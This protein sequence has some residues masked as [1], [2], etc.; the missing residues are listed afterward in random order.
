VQRHCPVGR[1]S[2][3]A[4]L[5][6]LG[7][8]K[9]AKCRLTGHPIKDLLVGSGAL[10]ETGL[11]LYDGRIVCEGLISPLAWIGCS[12]RL[13]ICWLHRQKAAETSERCD[14]TIGIFQSSLAIGGIVTKIDPP[15]NF[16]AT[17]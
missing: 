8:S 7:R 10:V 11:R 2:S 13:V 1:L 12:A 15:P 16:E 14:I 17:I 5:R 9:K 4:A 3:V 6:Q